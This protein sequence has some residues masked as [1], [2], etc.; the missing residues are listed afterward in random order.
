M[1]DIA[2]QHCF[3]TQIL[4]AALSL[5]EIIVID[6]QQCRRYNDIVMRL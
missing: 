5:P 2:Q 3:L 6:G 4:V 1:A